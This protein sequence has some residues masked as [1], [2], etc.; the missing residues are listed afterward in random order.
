MQQQAGRNGDN[1]RRDAASSGSASPLS[2][3]ASKMWADLH[4]EHTGDSPVTLSGAITG[5]L[6]HWAVKGAVQ[7]VDYRDARRLGPY[8]RVLKRVQ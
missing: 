4:F 1:A 5:K 3:V 6:Y 8:H 2:P 7:A